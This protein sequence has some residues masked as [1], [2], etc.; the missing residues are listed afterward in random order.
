M[1]SS[2]TA[3]EIWSQILSGWPSVTDS[4][5]NK[6]SRSC[7]CRYLDAAGGRRPE[8]VA[9]WRQSQRGESAPRFQFDV[10]DRVADG[11]TR[12]RL[13]ARLGDELWKSFPHLF[14]D[15]PFDLVDR[16]ERHG[17]LEQL[18]RIAQLGRAQDPLHRRDVRGVHGE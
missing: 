18:A 1:H 9:G 3:S 12:F 16:A 4:E 2:S 8:C 17:C 11:L 7:I 13:I 14:E 10:A 15:E 6:A 5:L